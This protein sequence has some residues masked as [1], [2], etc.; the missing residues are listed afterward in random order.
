MGRVKRRRPN[1][2]RWVRALEH[3]LNRLYDLRAKFIHCLEYADPIDVKGAREVEKKVPAAFHAAI[4]AA[5]DVEYHRPDDTIIFRA[6]EELRMYADGSVIRPSQIEA[7]IRP[8]SVILYA[9]RQP[10][11]KPIAKRRKPCPK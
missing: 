8:A 3:A 6:V 7:L 2:A 5:Q 9:A 10:L 4:V 11:P 1:V